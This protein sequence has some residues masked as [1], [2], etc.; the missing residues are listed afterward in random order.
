MNFFIRY[1]III[2]WILLFASCESKEGVIKSNLSEFIAKKIGNSSSIEI[3]N[4]KVINKEFDKKMGFDLYVESNLKT[5]SSNT[6]YLEVLFSAKNS[7]NEKIFRSVIIYLDSTKKNFVRTFP[8]NIGV[9]FGNIS[10]VGKFYIG[11]L[12]TGQQTQKYFDDAEILFVNVDTI[13]LGRKYLGK[14]VDG[15]FQI[16]KMIPG[17]YF[18]K[19]IDKRTILANIYE[20]YSRNKNY[21]I[22]KEIERFMFFYKNYNYGTEHYKYRNKK[23]FETT[24][25]SL[26][27]INRETFYSDEYVKNVWNNFKYSV[28]MKYIEDLDIEFDYLY[29]TEFDEI[30]INSSVPTTKDFDIKKFFF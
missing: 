1:S 10:G 26:E 11:Q 22:L 6:E 4:Y 9:E 17:K 2:L 29:L 20:N 27:K 8:E 16:N 30:D 25:S 28:D 5:Y 13:N 19:I 21:N 12:I 3:H 15:S 7:E 18:V 23:L 24:F 14:I